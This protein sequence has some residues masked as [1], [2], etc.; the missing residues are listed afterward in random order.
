MFAA[1]AASE[2]HADSVVSNAADLARLV[3]REQK[4][5]VAFNITG[6]DENG[7]F[8]DKTIGASATTVTGTGN[9]V[10]MTFPVTQRTYRRI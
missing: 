6:G 4:A 2:I 3:Y 7:A 1:V 8:W 5:D 9:T 10:S